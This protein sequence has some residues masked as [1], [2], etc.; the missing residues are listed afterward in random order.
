MYA[1]MNFR[2]EFLANR[3]GWGPTFTNEVKEARIFCGARQAGAYVSQNHLDGLGCRLVSMNKYRY[4]AVLQ[5]GIPEYDGLKWY[6]EYETDTVNTRWKKNIAEW[7]AYC[8][9]E[10]YTDRIQYRTIMR[11]ELN[12]QTN[13]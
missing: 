1:I 10:K 11:R 4:L 5:I 6:D 13:K 7:I 8:K 2:G 3:P 9:A 12:V